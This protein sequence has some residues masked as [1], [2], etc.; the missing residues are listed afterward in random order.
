MLFYKSLDREMVIKRSKRNLFDYYQE[1][2]KREE[3]KDEM[4]E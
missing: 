1:D 3:K 2:S 4:K